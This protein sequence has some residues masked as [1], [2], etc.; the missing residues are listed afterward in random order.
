MSL[1]A[2]REKLYSIEDDIKSGETELE[3]A[4]ARLMAEYSAEKEIKHRILGARVDLKRTLR[5]GNAREW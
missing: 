2:V 4:T 3:N 5:V 1:H